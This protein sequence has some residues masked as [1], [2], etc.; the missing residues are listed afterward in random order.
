MSNQQR[1]AGDSAI[2]YTRIHADIALPESSKD[3]VSGIFSASL[4]VYP[5]ANTVQLVAQPVN[6]DQYTVVSFKHPGGSFTVPYTVP[7]G[8]T[9]ILN[10]AGKDFRRVTVQ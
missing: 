10:V 4:P 1:L 2:A 5:F 6:G 9:L 7:K 8:T 3:T